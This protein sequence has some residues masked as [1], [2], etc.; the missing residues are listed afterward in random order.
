MPSYIAGIYISHNQGMEAIVAA[1]TLATLGVSIVRQNKLLKSATSEAGNPTAHPESLLGKLVTPIHALTL[2]A[3]PASY[4]V[5]VL[6]N[7]FHQPEWYTDLGGLP[8]ELDLKVGI[9]G[10]AWI[11]TGAALASIPMAYIQSWIFKTLGKQMHF[12][13]PREKGEIVSTGPYAYVRHPGYTL[14]LTQVIFWA[15]AFWSWI[16]L[17]GAGVCLVA[18]GVKIPIEEKLIEDDPALGPQYQEYK[19]KVPYRLIPFVW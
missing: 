4:L 12:I 3:V 11:R 5:A 16:P 6:S 13:S 10:K 14:A 7:S 15:P 1:S 2:L 8:L 9:G 19:R 18:F 17:V